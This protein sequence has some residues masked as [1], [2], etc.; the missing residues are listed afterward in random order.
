MST[1][2]IIILICLNITISQSDD[3]IL[4]EFS[5]NYIDINRINKSNIDCYFED[6][7]SKKEFSYQIYLVSYEE[8]ESG[9]TVQ[10]TDN[11][12]YVYVTS[13]VKLKKMTHKTLTNKKLSITI[14]YGY[15]AKISI[16]IESTER[17]YEIILPGIIGV[18]KKNY[19]C[20]NIPDNKK[21][22]VIQF[23][24]NNKD[25][26]IFYENNYYNI[27]FFIFPNN[28]TVIPG[29][30]DLIF[31]IAP[32]VIK[33]YFGYYFIISSNSG[34]TYH[35]NSIFENNDLKEKKEFVLQN[36]INKIKL[37]NNNYHKNIV[38]KFFTQIK[39]NDN[40]YITLLIDNKRVLNETKTCNKKE[41]CF[42]N[43]GFSY[44]GN[45][46]YIEIENHNNITFK[47]E[48]TNNTD[49]KYYPTDL[50]SF[51][52]FLI[53]L[54][55]LIIIAA[56]GGGVYWFINDKMKN[57]TFETFNFKDKEAKEMQ[58][59]LTKV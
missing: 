55:I 58:Q 37:P 3:L 44:P 45:N 53:V 5:Q 29:N 49:P 27:P 10:V 50:S 7:L 18:T 1:K 33:D 41:K 13:S 6:N 28:K 19:S 4:N 25:E 56:I 39:D 32:F 43:I 54:L 30:E 51:Q 57:P 46:N 26:E 34:I 17:N 47:Y 59:G 14:K 31:N 11:E 42:M 16:M 21:N 9:L 8:D 48:F 52:I 23:V 36:G 2:L 40:L 35:F 22:Y 38:L 15:S 24:H 20:F 12:E